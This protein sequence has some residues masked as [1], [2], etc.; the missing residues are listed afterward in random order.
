MSAPFVPLEPSRAVLGDEVYARLG[1]AIL[2]GRLAPGERLRDQE[3]AEWLG[4]SRTP[5]REALQ[6]LERAGLVEVSPHR[7]TRVSHPHQQSDTVE[8]VAFNMGLAVRMASARADADALDLALERLD[9]VIAASRAND[10][11]TLAMA[12]H[13][14][15]SVVTHAS[16]NFALL[17][18]VREYEFAI[19]RDMVGWR[20]FIECP[21]G[22]T[23]AYEEFRE[24]FV[25]RDADRAESLLRT[26]HG[27]S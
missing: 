19:R 13:A 4:V 25:S 23:A 12:S 9:D 15:F 27:L 1:E 14:F 24:A 8:L 16:G 5:V 22:R 20:P 11:D 17:Q 6:R 18:F 7:Y 3:L 10:P 2:D 21:I 26:I